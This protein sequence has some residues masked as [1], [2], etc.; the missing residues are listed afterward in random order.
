MED[1]S[2]KNPETLVVV[3]RDQIM[4][5]VLQILASVDARLMKDAPKETRGRVAAGLDM[6][7]YRGM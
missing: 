4:G 1:W 6:D 7:N 5:K 3:S 2:L